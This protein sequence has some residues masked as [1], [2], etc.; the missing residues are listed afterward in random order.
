MFSLL[1]P[2]SRVRKT[3][4]SLEIW[5]H[6]VHNQDDLMDNIEIV[7]FSKIAYASNLL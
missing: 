6:H 2:L 4:L 1:A 5:K 3:N 7:S